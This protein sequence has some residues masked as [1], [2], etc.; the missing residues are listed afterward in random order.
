M[1]PRFRNNRSAWACTS[2][3]SRRASRARNHIDLHLC[4]RRN[5]HQRWEALL[6]DTTVHAVRPNRRPARL[7]WEQ[8][9]APRIGARPAPRG[10]ARAALHVAAAHRRDRRRHDPRSDVLRS[11]RMARTREGLV[12]PR[13]DPRRG[14]ARATCDRVHQRVHRRAPARPLQPP[15]RDHR[16][17]ARRRPRALRAEP[18]AGAH[19]RRCGSRRTE[20]SPPYVA[21]A[22]TI[23]PRKD[24]PTLVRAFARIADAHPKLRLVLAGGDGWG[25][26]A[27]RDAIAASGVST[28]VVR[29]GYL[30]D[31]TLAALFRR[32]DCGRV[33]LARRGL[34]A[35]RPRSTREWNPARLHDWL[36]RPRGRRRRRARSTPPGDVDALGGLARAVLDDDALA[37]HLRAAGPE[38]AAVFTWTRSID[39]HI[40][41]YRHAVLLPA[42]A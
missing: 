22:G 7:A 23:E 39:G 4:A 19:R 2:S 33:P 42:S 20:S 14:V 5:D 8:Y 10:V 35:S 12:L 9:G 26:D 28:R 6:P 24:I 18:R 11:S 41:A 3:N 29:P 25:V 36:G 1:F 37:A 30:D 31:D 38:R 34:R 17:A 13:D 16:C 27:A 21:F 40:D 32:A 15:G